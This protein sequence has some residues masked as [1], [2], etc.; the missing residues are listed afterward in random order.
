MAERSY[1]ILLRV[2][3]PKAEEVP[4]RVERALKHAQ[5]IKKVQEKFPA[6][7]RASFIVPQDYDCGQTAE[8]LLKRFNDEGMSHDVT[9]STSSGHHSCEVLNYGLADLRYDI[10]ITHG[11]IVSGK[12]M[13][14]LTVENLRKI[15][16]VL[17]SGAMVAGLATDELR[18]I[19]LS[20][21]IQ[22]TF[23]AWDIHALRGIG[24][25]DSRGG[26]EEIAPLIRLAREYGKCIAPID[27]DY[28]TLDIHKSQ[29]AN[30][31]HE[32]VMRTKLERQLEE[33]KR[34]NSD[35]EFIRNAIMQ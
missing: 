34:L 21:R 7:R 2:Y 28:G 12:A 32:E 33:C 29:T 22:N 13:P 31:R 16:D 9:V 26:V 14:Y 24:G 35:F 10:T 19:V 8:T 17:E 27:V 23:A 18:D 5:Q 1:G 20:G 6:L 25:F 30:A 3:T 4:D 11:L 15:D